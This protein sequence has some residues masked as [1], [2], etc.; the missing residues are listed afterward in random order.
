MHLKDEPTIRVDDL[1][2]ATTV[3]AKEAVETT[4]TE[5]PLS[6]IIRADRPAL[7]FAY[8][9]NLS[10][11]QMRYRC[12]NDPDLSAHPVA[13]ARLDG[14]R[15]LICEAGY[16]NVIPPRELRVGEQ[17]THGDLVP[18]SRGGEGGKEEEDQGAIYGVLYEMSDADEFLLDGY[19]GVDHAAPDARPLIDRKVRPKEQGM[20]DYN[21]WYVRAT[22]I[23]WL[24]EEQRKSRL[25]DGDQ[26][27]V[28]IYVD[29]DR[30]RL[31]P[32]REEY[33]GR[34]NR[35][36]AE[37]EQIGF[38]ADWAEAVMRKSIPKQ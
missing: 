1:P 11:T 12:T 32:P 25:A 7:Y 33:I 31:G 22:V 5:R 17:V 3:V 9:S 27:P 2:P 8:G 20:G 16:A 10:F 38:P 26:Q 24:D 19:E 6:E 15:W 28:L 18:I 30:V 37:A 29:E 34:M 4:E 36:I 14:W 23:N 13:I 21:K 35:A